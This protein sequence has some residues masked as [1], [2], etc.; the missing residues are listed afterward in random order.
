MMEKSAGGMGRT[1]GSTRG[2]MVGGDELVEEGVVG[3]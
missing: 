1:G 2:V 3:R